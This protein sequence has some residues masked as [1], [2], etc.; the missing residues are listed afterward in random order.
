VGEEREKSRWESHA[1]GLS[2]WMHALAERLRF[3]RVCCGDFRRVLTPAVTVGLGTTGVFLD[4][5]YCHA[6]RDGGLY[7][8]EDAS[9]SA[10]AREWAIAHGDDPRYRI[11]LAGYEGEHAMPGSWEVVH[12]KAQGGYA[13]LSKGDA[14]EKNANARKERLWFSPHCEKV[15]LFG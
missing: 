6:L 11:C 2:A 15:G 5:P 8:T 10:K 12:W 1:D 7:A 4:P 3:V 14:E 13:N 9:A